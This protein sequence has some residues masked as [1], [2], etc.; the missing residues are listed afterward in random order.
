MKEGEK[1]PIIEAMSVDLSK[2]KDKKQT[3]M[4]IDY[5]KNSS[6][7]EKAYFQP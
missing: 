6:E 3:H 7:E 1:D 4:R 2:E 5:F